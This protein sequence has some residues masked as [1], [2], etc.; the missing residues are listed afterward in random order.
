MTIMNTTANAHEAALRKRIQDLLCDYSRTH[1]TTDYVEF[2]TEV[3]ADFLDTLHEIPTTDPYAL[4]LPPEPMAVLLQLYRIVSHS[5]AEDALSK[6]VPEEEWIVYP[7]SVALVKSVLGMQKGGGGGSR[8]ERAVW[9]SGP[10]LQL[11]ELP[12]ITALTAHSRRATPKL[13]KGKY[14]RQI[15]KMLGNVSRKCKFLACKVEEVPSAKVMIEDVLRTEV[16]INPDEMNQVKATMQATLAMLKPRPVSSSNS[17]N[18][19]L[20]RLLARPISPPPSD[21]LPEIAAPIF[22]MRRRPGCGRREGGG[23]VPLPPLPNVPGDTKEMIEMVDSM[24]A[25]APVVVDSDDDIPKQN[26]RVV[27]A[28]LH[29]SPSVHSDSAASQ[30]EDELVDQLEMPPT[31]DTSSDPALQL[32]ECLEKPVTEVIFPRARRIGGLEGVKEHILHGKTYQSFMNEVLPKPEPKSKSDESSNPPSIAPG[33]ENLSKTRSSSPPAT[34]MLG[35]ASTTLEPSEGEGETGAQASSDGIEALYGSTLGLDVNVYT[36]ILDEKIEDRSSFVLEVPALPEP[37]HYRTSHFIPTSFRDWTQ[38]PVANDTRDVSGTT[39]APAACHSQLRALFKKARISQSLLLSLSWV[40]FTSTEQIPTIAE[41]VQ[42]DNVFSSRRGEPV[43]LGLVKA[44]DRL[45]EPL[46]VSS[47]LGN[48][49]ASSATNKDDSQQYGDTV[50]SRILAHW[51]AMDD[52]KHPY[53]SVYD[54]DL[55]LDTPLVLSRLD[56]LRLAR[57]RKTHARI[58]SVEDEYCRPEHQDGSSDL[59]V[60]PDSEQGEVADGGEADGVNARL[61]TRSTLTTRPLAGALSEEFEDVGGSTSRTRAKRMKMGMSPGFG[62][63][64]GTTAQDALLDP[65]RHPH[66]QPRTRYP[67]V[68][69]FA[70]FDLPPA[71][72][73]QEEKENWN[74]SASL[75]GDGDHDYLAVDAQLA[76][77]PDDVFDDILMSP[78]LEYVDDDPHFAVKDDG[79]AMPL[80]Y[81][82]GLDMPIALDVDDL[83]TPIAMDVGDSFDT[84]GMQQQSLEFDA[85]PIETQSNGPTQANRSQSSVAKHTT[86]APEP[87]DAPPLGEHNP[88]PQPRKAKDPTSLFNCSLGVLGFATLRSARLKDAPTP[89]P[90]PIADTGPSLEPEDEPTNHSPPDEIFDRNTIRLD[91]NAPPPTSTHRYLASLELLQRRALVNALQSPQCR[92]DLIER[93]SLGGGGPHLILD[94][95]TAVLLVPLLT[96][97]AQSQSAALIERLTELARRFGYVDVVFEAF[98]ESCAMRSREGRSDV[99]AWTPPVLKAIKKVRRDWG[100]AVVC[101]ESR[102]GGGA[103]GRCR[104]R[105]G[106]AGS[107][108]EVAQIVR[109]CGEEAERRDGTGGVLWD[110]REW[111][112]DEHEIT[113]D[114]FINLEP[115]ERVRMFGP[116]VGEDAMIAFNEEIQ[117]RYEAMASSSSL[118]EGSCA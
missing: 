2:T 51:G 37:T 36:P 86:K 85:L 11:L 55:E 46:N 109:L 107:V 73:F 61:L 66:Q 97:P 94:A 12:C 77:N 96:L 110:G 45:L 111:L 75:L 115:E 44:V 65:R 18:P 60:G 76:L 81:G 22:P 16:T 93:P 32:Y 91:P 49:G 43:D 82:D 6:T 87:P 29:S 113:L 21:P 47:S 108:A 50:S 3:V 64:L 104:V 92:I 56:R 26:M 67:S 38:S 7:E 105:W 70:D 101:D 112:E 79:S 95:F 63:D 117:R 103:L 24:G 116:Y 48:D 80:E 31:P 39:T 118:I 71:L 59:E 15:P 98:P 102:R 57:K 84:I 14:L 72:S 19:V 5:T 106:F 74:P 83:D 78:G 27:D 33:T 42:V 23:R 68:N 53:Y 4:V 1:Y 41:V 99:C 13:G 9:E 35:L 28:T 88:T 58:D 34:S 17:N 54:L 100:I 52:S 10:D 30:E 25:L 114:D 8:S 40:A 69:A 62:D 89:V 20:E 90:E